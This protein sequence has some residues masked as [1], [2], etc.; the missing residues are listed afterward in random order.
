MVNP[1]EKFVETVR[2]LAKERLSLPHFE[3]NAAGDDEMDSNFMDSEPDFDV[4]SNVVSS[5]P[6]EYD[7][8]YEVEESQ[9]DYNL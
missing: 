9:E 8:I 3:G 7:V 6:V 2:R 4:I 5:L 1:Q